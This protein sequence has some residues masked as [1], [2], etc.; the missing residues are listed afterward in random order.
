MANKKVVR[1]DPT[2]TPEKRGSTRG[3][4]I[5]EPA[6]D[7]KPTPEAKS[8]ATKLRIFAALA[9]VA[10]IAIEGY[11]I[12]GVLR[13]AGEVNLVLLCVLIVVIGALAI[14]G[15]LLWKKANRLDP[16]RRADTVRFF[17]QNQLGAL[18]TLL[19]FLPLIA[20]ILLDKDMDKKEKAISG[21]LGVVVMLIAGYFGIDWDAPSVEQYAEETSQVEDITGQNLVYWT[22]SGDVFHLCE[23]V[24]AVN[25]ESKDNTIYSGTVA[26]AHAA[27][28]SRLTL[29]VE[30][31]RKQCGFADTDDLTP[32]PTPTET[33]TP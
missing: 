11:A 16:A 10:A 13:R 19:A 27:G 26:D 25:L 2:D 31:E 33:A 23:E 7:W 22:K 12:F 6:P 32:S 17:V 24:S 30:Q 15:S 4:A 29:Q 3:S 21:G 1:V 14:T 28:K 5:P 8:S 20:L 9:W 18:I